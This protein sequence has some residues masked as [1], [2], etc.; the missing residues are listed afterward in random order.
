MPVNIYM[1]KL[2]TLSLAII[3][4]SSCARYYVGKVSDHFDGT[5]FYDP[6]INYEA[7]F[8]DF[9]KWRLTSNSVSWPD[10]IE[11]DQYDVPPQRVYI[12]LQQAMQKD[13]T[14]H[15]V[16]ILEVGASWYVPL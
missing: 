8:W 10:K 16:K 6:E 14:G 13:H 12:N 7:S 11:V 2:L 15:K 1:K 4:L 3:L 9:L 5:R